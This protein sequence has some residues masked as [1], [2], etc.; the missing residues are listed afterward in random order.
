MIKKLNHRDPGVWCGNPY[1]KLTLL[2]RNLKI[3]TPCLP[4]SNQH[5][6][7]GILAFGMFTTTSSPTIIL[8]IAV[9]KSYCV[10]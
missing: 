10:R 9:D 3:T 8:A 7:G 2:F 5:I 4:S 6:W 1:L